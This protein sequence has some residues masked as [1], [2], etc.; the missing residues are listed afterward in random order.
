MDFNPDQFRQ[1]AFRGFGDQAMR[2]YRVSPTTPDTDPTP[3][4]SSQPT[5][6]VQPQLPDP[7]AAAQP[8][9]NVPLSDAAR[10]RADVATARA[11]ARQARVATAQANATAATHRQTIAE[12]R[13]TQLG[14]RAAAATAPPARPRTVDPASVPD[15]TPPPL[16]GTPAGPGRTGSINSLAFRSQGQRFGAAPPPAAPAPSAAT[17]RPTTP[18]R[19]ATAPPASAPAPASR[20]SPGAAR[21]GRTAAVG[22][23]VAAKAL[24]SL[25]RP[26]T[27]PKRSGNPLYKSN[28][29]WSRS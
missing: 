12:A 27:D 26:A 19:P 13:A 21:A 6:W 7:P 2:R 20:V 9:G 17:G 11:Q 24:Q 8:V 3:A 15:H 18:P 10:A 23:F 29:G 1:G 16:P 25:S 5:G 28:N 14:Q 22:A 4:P